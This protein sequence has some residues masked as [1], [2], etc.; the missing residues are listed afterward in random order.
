MDFH[1][2]EAPRAFMLNRVC[3]VGPKKKIA[4]E[5][6]KTPLLHKVL[7]K[8]FTTGLVAEILESRRLAQVRAATKSIRRRPLILKVVNAGSKQ[9]C[10]KR[11]EPLVQ[12]PQSRPIPESK[13]QENAEPMET[14]PNNAIEKPARKQQLSTTPPPPPPPTRSSPYTHTVV[15]RK[16]LKRGWSDEDEQSLRESDEDELLNESEESDESDTEI[17]QPPPVSSRLRKRSRLLPPKKTRDMCLKGNKHDT[18]AIVTCSKS[19]GS[20]AK[21]VLHSLRAL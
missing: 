7:N 13:L 20:K 21:F 2:Q 14:Q 17:I 16:M 1:F 5:Q 15:V 4:M 18:V 12:Q 3:S 10:A 11:E 8:N 9:V 19:R 6:P